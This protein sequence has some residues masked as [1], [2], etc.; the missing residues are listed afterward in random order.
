L[1]G[2]AWRPI[3]GHRNLHVAIGRTTGRPEAS[4]GTRSEEGVF[5]FIEGEDL[6]RELG[7]GAA[8]LQ[9]DRRTIE[10]PGKSPKEAKEPHIK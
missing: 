2:E 5:P 8:P 4:S 3:E 9:P 10:K 7:V 1:R 6:L